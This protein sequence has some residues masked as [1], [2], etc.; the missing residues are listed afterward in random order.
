MLICITKILNRYSRC[1][2]L[3]KSLCQN[4]IKCIHREWIMD[5]D[6]VTWDKY[7]RNN[8]QGYNSLPKPSR[9][10]MTDIHRM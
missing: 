6:Y 9:G 1:F 3:S 5:V 7:Y 10:I 8:V 2:T 4:S